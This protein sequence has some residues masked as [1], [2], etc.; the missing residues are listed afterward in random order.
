MN[1]PTTPCTMTFRPRKW[2]D[3]HVENNVTVTPWTAETMRT[4]YARLYHKARRH[5][6]R[7]KRR[8]ESRKPPLVC[9]ECGGAGGET[10]YVTDD[11]GPWMECGWCEGTG[12]VDNHRRG[13]WLRWR[14]QLTQ[15]A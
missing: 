3:G 14:I 11:G 6:A 5:H 8:V 7:W 1:W 9:Q 15:N 10:E 12:L 13:E 2:K 4:Y